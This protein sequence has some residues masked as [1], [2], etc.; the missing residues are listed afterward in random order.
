MKDIMLSYMSERIHGIRMPTQAVVTVEVS[1]GVQV[2]LSPS[3]E[4]VEQ[5][6]RGLDNLLKYRDAQGVKVAAATVAAHPNGLH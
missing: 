4:Q 5:M 1:P 2:S 6:A 3:W